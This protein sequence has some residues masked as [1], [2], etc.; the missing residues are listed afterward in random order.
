MITDLVIKEVE[1]SLAKKFSKVNVVPEDEAYPTSGSSFIR[2][3]GEFT[4]IK[5]T[6]GAV[7]FQVSFSVS[8]SIRTR[9]FLKQ[10]KHKPYYS[11]ITLQESCF[12]HITSDTSLTS[13]LID[14]A[15]GISITGRFTSNSINTRVQKVGP[16]FYGSKDMSSTREAG[17]VLTQRYLSPKI[18]VPLTCLTYPSDLI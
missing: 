11:L 6:E 17:Y 5:M 8:C 4:D 9:D 3:S 10:N 14:I 15:T 7:I 12:F 13:K 2:V 1:K 18:F 16:N